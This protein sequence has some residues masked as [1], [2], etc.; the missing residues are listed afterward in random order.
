M[1]A[2]ACVRSLAAG[3]KELHLCMTQSLVHG[4]RFLLAHDSRVHCPLAASLNPLDRVGMS[5]GSRIFI[6]VAHPPIWGAW[7][8][9]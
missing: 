8:Q 9:L 6:V 5:D 3:P 7:L 2:C 1:C 4:L